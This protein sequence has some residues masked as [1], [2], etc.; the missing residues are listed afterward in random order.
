MISKTFSGYA[1][2]V[3][4]VAMLFIC[5]A[6]LA[7]PASAATAYPGGAPSFSATVAGVNEFTPGEDTTLSIQIKNSGVNPV[8]QLGRGTIEPEDLPNTAKF[9]TVSLGSAGDAVLIRSDPQMVGD[10]RGS[11]NSVTVSFKAKISANATEGEYQLPLT[12]RYQYA[13]VENQE[14][15][16]VF[17]FTYDDAENTLPVIL[18]IKPHVKAEVVDVVPE[19]LSVGSQGYLNLTILNAGTEDGKMAVVKLL[20]NGQSP[21]IPADS[22]VYIG[23]FPRGEKVTCRYKVSISRDAM[24]QTYPVDLVVTYSNREGA[25]VSSATTTVGVPVLAKTAFSIVSPS[26]EIPAGSSR[27]IEIQYRN[28]GVVTAY[29]AQAR[30]AQHDPLTVSDNNAFLGDISPGKT[31]TARYEVQADTDAEPKE[32]SFDST[33]RY[34]DALG[35]SLESE[36]LPV[37]ITVVA[38]ASGISVV[39]GGLPALAGCVIAGIVICMAFLAYRPRR[40]NR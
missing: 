8:K 4:L 35:N 28:D 21:V 24:D 3:L 14:A 33:I 20:R 23:S 25:V 7:A 13:R 30:I 19:G 39:P 38:A 16:D 32:Y 5:S 11:G 37:Q 22:S 12:L 18:R 26:S 6:L 36:T 17:A 2:N 10:I 27:I 34:R 31:V 29:N 40:E 15:A 9:V 1:G